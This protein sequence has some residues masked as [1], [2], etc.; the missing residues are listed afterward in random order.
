MSRF[1]RGRERELCSGLLESIFLFLF[2]PWAFQF[3]VTEVGW[4]SLRAA[5]AYHGR[6][7]DGRAR[8][9]TSAAIFGGAQSIVVRF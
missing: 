5:E 4:K 8:T 3:R 2:A 6:L 9:C 7:S 1:K